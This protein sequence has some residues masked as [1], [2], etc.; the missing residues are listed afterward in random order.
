[1][2]SSLQPVFVHRVNSDGTTVSFCRECFATVASSMWE[3]ELE[4]A[5]STHR[6][7]P[8]RL[9]YLRRAAKEGWNPDRK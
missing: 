8:S 3:A 2:L 1:M 5:E 7:D 6:C 9:E 4:R